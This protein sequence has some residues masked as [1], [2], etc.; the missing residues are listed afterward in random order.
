MYSHHGIGSVTISLSFCAD[1][2]RG[3]LKASLCELVN[4]FGV[5]Q[6][7]S[8]QGTRKDKNDPVSKIKVTGQILFQ[9]PTSPFASHQIKIKG[10]RR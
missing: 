6:V 3:P 9:E 8:E 2:Q 4:L 10:V 5:D 1:F 7:S